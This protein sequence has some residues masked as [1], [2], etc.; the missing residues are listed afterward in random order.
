MYFSA[1]GVVLIPEE[2]DMQF[3]IRVGMIVDPKQTL[4]TRPNPD[5]AYARAHDYCQCN[6]CDL[7]HS[8]G[9]WY[10]IGGCCY[11]TTYMR[12]NDRMNHIPNT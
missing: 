2:I 8:L 9:T 3:I 5:Y 7:Q 6:V 11:P 12:I 10:C 4:F 1:I